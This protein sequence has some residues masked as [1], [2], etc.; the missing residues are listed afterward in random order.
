VKGRSRLFVRWGAVVAYSALIFFLSSLSDL[1]VL[2]RVSWFDFEGRDKVEHG[3]AYTIWA[4]IFSSARA[5]TWPASPRTAVWIA[6]SM[7]ILY[8]VSDEIHQRYV[9]GR[10]ASLYDLAVDAAGS[11]LGALIHAAWRR[12]KT[13]ASRRFPGEI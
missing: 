12:K 2:D 7:G 11:L 3:I 4:F 9:P 1:H 6:T 13:R 5:A 8:G 10:T